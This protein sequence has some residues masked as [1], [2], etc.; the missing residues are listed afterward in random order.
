MNTDT[1][2]TENDAIVEQARQA[3]GPALLDTAAGGELAVFHT[4]T[5]LEVVDLDADKYARRADRP[6]RK[7]GTTVVRDVRSFAQY[8]R[9]HSDEHSEVYVILDEGLIIAVLD[10]HQ[11]EPDA[12][13]WGDH[14]LQLRLTP[15]EAWQRW[16]AQNRRLLPQVAFAEFLEDNL[17]DLASQPVPAAEVLEIARTFQART[18]VSFSSGIVQAS[19]D[20]RLK[21]EETTDATGGARGELTVPNE[22]AVALA[23]FDDTDRYL[24]RARLRHRI[25]GGNLRLMY[26]LDRP[27]EHLREAVKT[28]VEKVEAEIGVQIMRGAPPT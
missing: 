18:K 12:P 24:I 19:G 16:G 2:R 4:P 15:T 22:F 3:A 17:D 11:P 20:I 8:Y 28:V 1:T 10:A 13:R 21:Y 25:E 6:R 9:K 14:V 7:Q 23:A 5:G 27:E 26:I